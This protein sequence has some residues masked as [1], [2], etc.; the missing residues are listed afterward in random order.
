MFRLIKEIFT[1]LLNFIRSLPTK[2]VSL[3]NEPCISPTL[4]DSNSVEVKCCPFVISLNKCIGSCNSINDLFKKLTIIYLISQLVSRFAGNT[5]VIV[6]AS[7][8]PPVSFVKQPQ[9]RPIIKSSS[10]Q[11]LTSHHQSINW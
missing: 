5:K 8:S 6:G 2:G 1:A 3:N 10:N 9:Q 4:I 7:L 11:K